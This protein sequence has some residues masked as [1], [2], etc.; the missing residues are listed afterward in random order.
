MAEGFLVF[1][2]IFFLN[3]MNDEGNGEKKVDQ[4]ENYA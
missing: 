1:S 3:R 4:N 2:M